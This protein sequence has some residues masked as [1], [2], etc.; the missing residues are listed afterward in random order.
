[1]GRQR[2]C[3]LGMHDFKESSRSYCNCSCCHSS[4]S[5]QSTSIG[6]DGNCSGSFGTDKSGDSTGCWRTELSS[7][8]RE[9]CG[10]ESVEDCQPGQ[11]ASAC[12]VHSTTE[13]HS[14]TNH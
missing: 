6:T 4:G 9:C 8:A 14:S 3:V 2:R 10:F 13:K 5:S 11:S 12:S 1:M 7:V